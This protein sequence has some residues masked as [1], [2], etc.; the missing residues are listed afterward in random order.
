MENLLNIK[1]NRKHS[2][3]E[4]LIKKFETSYDVSRSA[5]F[6]RA[7][8]AAQSVP[9]WRETHTL[10]LEVKEIDEAPLFTNFQAKYDDETEN[11]LK[12]VRVKMFSD[13]KAIG[14]KVLRKQYM[15]FLLQ[16]NYLE[17]LQKDKL[18]IR[19]EHI[20]EENKDLPEIMKSLMQ[21][22]ILDK[23][24]DSLKRISEIIIEWRNNR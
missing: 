12:E 24:C 4:F 23:D 9:D 7:V 22:I 11:I 3:L 20:N 5:I 15:L 1:C 10:G 18:A 6:E 13:L 21:M 19:T 16:V 14:F 2:T 17:K 8:K